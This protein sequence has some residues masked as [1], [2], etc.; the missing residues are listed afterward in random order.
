MKKIQKHK[1]LDYDF[2]DYAEEITGNALFK[3]NG[4]AEVENSH[5]GV[6]GAKPGDTI[7]RIDGTV[8][9]L[10]QAD[11][12]YANAQLR[13]NGNN[14]TGNTNGSSSAGTSSGDTSSSSTQNDYFELPEANPNAY[15]YYMSKQ[16][17]AKAEGN[18][19]KYKGYN[20]YGTGRKIEETVAGEDIRTYVLVVRQN[21][22]LGN[23]FDSDRYVYKNGVMVFHDKVGANCRAEYL[24]EENFTEPDGEYYFTTKGLPK[25]T[26]G[27]FDSNSYH[28][29]LIHQTNDPKIPKEIR[30][31]INI[32]PRNFLEH[33]NQYKISADLKEK[34]GTIYGDNLYPYSAG[35][36][37]G[38]DGQ[39]HHDLYM[40]VLLNGVSNVENIRKEIRSIS[41]LGV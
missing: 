23:S 5:E 32:S 33:C 20:I 21:D 2:S 10:K 22:G 40:S 14:G 15:A 30:D 41:N 13:N 39:E 9:T 6:A 4:G 25:N 35:C 36:T 31:K 11:I 24:D 8:V 18:P 27:T 37:I 17:E 7:T 34:S 16:G 1:T 26:D 29:V 3:I 19:N 28:N 12:D 38:K